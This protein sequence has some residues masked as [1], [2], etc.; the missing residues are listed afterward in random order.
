MLK[1][2]KVEFIEKGNELFQELKNAKGRSFEIPSL[3]P[4]LELIQYAKDKSE[5]SKKTDIKIVVHDLHTGLNPT[6]GFSIKSMI[7]KEATLFN[8]GDGTNFIYKFSDIKLTEEEVKLLNDEN[9]KGK[10]SKITL[11][12]NSLL[13]KGAKIN[14]IEIQSDNLKR[15]LELIDTKL[16]EILSYLL[17][18]KYAYG[19][20][21]SFDELL[22]VILVK[23]PLNF[24]LSNAHPFYEYKLKNFLADA[25]LGMTPETIWKGV[26]DATGGIIIVKED[27]EVVCYHIYNRNDFQD[28]LL[29]NT[30]LNQTSTTRYKWGNLYLQ[31]NV[32]H[33]KLN[34]C[35]RFND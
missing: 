27:G 14:F 26:Y 18:Y 30:K 1:V 20:K 6:L 23:N 25:A 11:R 7:G 17:L 10:E 22:K 29:N 34:L 32:P 15:N 35:V 28:Y 19:V 12:I 21:S 24:N 33:I 2:S 3:V 4:F 13:K 8:G 9:P 5:H 16:P 31:D